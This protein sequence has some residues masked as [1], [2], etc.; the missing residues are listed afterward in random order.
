MTYYLSEHG[1]TVSDALRAC[2]A[3]LDWQNQNLKLLK[4]S[5]MQSLSDLR[6][7]PRRSSFKVM[8]D[9]FRPRTGGCGLGG[10]GCGAQRLWRG[11]WGGS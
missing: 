7:K 3:D 1:G 6:R 11:A 10:C 4:Q 9:W 5:S 8:M 2:Q